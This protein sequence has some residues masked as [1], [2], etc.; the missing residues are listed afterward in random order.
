[1]K[2][3]NYTKNNEDNYKKKPLKQIYTKTITKAIKKT[4]ETSYAKTKKNYTP[5]H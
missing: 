2:K 3:K 1:M 4:Y 5:N